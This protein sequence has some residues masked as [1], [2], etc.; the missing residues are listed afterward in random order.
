[1]VPS[2]VWSRNW[3]SPVAEELF[4]LALGLR[5]DSRIGGFSRYLKPAPVAR[6]A[7]LIAPV[8]RVA[9]SVVAP[10][11][12]AAISIAASIGRAPW[13][14]SRTPRRLAPLPLMV[15]DGLNGTA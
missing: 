8:T 12:R 15:N 2:Q 6:A 13:A 5:L 10:L 1:M 3:N 11:I 7:S 4:A 9:T 14:V